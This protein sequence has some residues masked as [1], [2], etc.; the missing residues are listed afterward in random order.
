VAFFTLLAVFPGI[1][2]IVSLYGL[3][4]DTSTIGDHL[5]LLAGIL[6]FGILQLVADALTVV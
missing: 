2:A 3:F 5:T 4:A 6:P 1:A